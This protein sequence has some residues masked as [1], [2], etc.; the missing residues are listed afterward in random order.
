MDCVP[1]KIDAAALWAEI[2]DRLAPLLRLNEF[3]RTLYYYLLRKTVL[4][5][6]RKTAR[7]TNHV[8][9]R[10][11]GR[12][13]G[14][15]A[16]RRL[17]GF[18]AKGCVHVLESRVGDWGV[19]V[20]TPEEVLGRLDQGEALADPPGQRGLSGDPR[21]RLAL[22][23]REGGRCYYCFGPL[24]EKTLTIDHVVPFC[25]G[26]RDRLDNLVACCFPCNVAK[27]GGTAE[28][29]LRVLYR[30]ETI[31][32]SELH[33]R[34]EDLKAL[35]EGGRVPRGLNRKKKVKYVVERVLPLVRS[36]HARVV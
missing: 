29:F 26:G 9:A 19:W 15:I 10:L 12:P 16:W 14:T 23:R 1:S 22:M 8:I 20:L 32:N 11:T 21:V 3:E 2:E 13:A 24:N 28:E 18:F 6:G 17:H 31:T 25:A 27:G 33:F 30:R 34:L 4:H 5:G 7:I 35:R 36:N